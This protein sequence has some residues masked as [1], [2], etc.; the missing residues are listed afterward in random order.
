MA[1]VDLRIATCVALPEPDVD[2]APL[3]AA[4]AAAGLS[5]ALVGWDDPAADWD[6][7][8]PT[9]LRSTWNYPVAPDAFLAW[10]DRA[11]AAAPMQNPPDVVRGNLHKRYLLELAARGVPTVPTLLV[12][13]GQR[14]EL[15]AIAAP[16]AAPGAAASVVIKPAIGAA[17]MATRRFA[18][19]DPAALAHLAAITAERAA[20]IQPYVASVDGHGERALVWIDGELSHAVRKR[21]RFTGDAEQVDG[22]VAIADDER[23]VAAAALAPVA[24]RILYGRVDI[25][26]DATGQPMVM[27]LELIEPSLY[28]GHHAPAMARFVAAIGRW[29]AEQPASR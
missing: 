25:A 7:P 9:L 4:L 16:G 21:P 12:E 3:A 27:E 23:A 8:I 11:G 14:C 22:P 13:R 5:A 10:V 18:P 15:A 24:D 26:R 17:S 6:A 20:L 19:G 2:Q 1:A 28:L 29:L